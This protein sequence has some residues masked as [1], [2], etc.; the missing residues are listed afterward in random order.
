MG[1]ILQEMEGI[2]IALSRRGDKYPGKFNFT[3]SLKK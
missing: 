2:A 1:K 3:Y